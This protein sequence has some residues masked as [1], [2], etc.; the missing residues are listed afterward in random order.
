MTN[1]NSSLPLKTPSMIFLSLQHVLVMYAGAVSIP[2]IVGGALGLSTAEIAFL[3]TADLFVCGIATLIQTIGFKNVGIRLP[4]MMGVTFTAVGPM[5]AIGTNPDMGLLSIFGATIVAG[6]FGFLVSPFVGKLIRF[7]PPVVTGT[8][9]LVIGL[10]L[11]GIAGTWAAGGYGV[12]DFGNPLYLSIAACVL[13]TIIVISRYV[14]GFFGNISVLIGLIIGYVIAAFSGLISLDKIDDSPW[15][16]WVMPFHF[17]MPEFNFWAILAM[18]VVMLV[19]FIETTG[20]FMAVGEVVDEEINEEKLTRG[21]KADSLGTMIGGI[22]NIFPY[23]SYAQNIG[24]LS[25]TGVK[26]RSV[27]A[28]AGVFLIVLGLFPKLAYFVASIPSCVLGG[29]A[30]FMFGMVTSN[31]IKVL[32]R[33]D[34][35]NV[36]NLYVIAIST[37]IGMLP[38]FSPTIFSNLPASLSPLLNSPILL[39]AFCAVTLNVILNRKSESMKCADEQLKGA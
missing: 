11:I 21:F 5:I 32:Q 16:G 14:K 38:V 2:L 31:G 30:L 23:T 4:V 29:A 33:V 34:F 25:I 1:K 39:T 6:I 26:N 20:M 17:G 22:F 37:S 13:F 3:I 12:K 24:L 9:I 27:C 8:Q 10:S 18:C 36:N 28:L 15:L 7:F 19:I 35:E